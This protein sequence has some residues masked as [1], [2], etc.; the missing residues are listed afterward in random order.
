[1]GGIGRRCEKLGGRCS[2]KLRF[3]APGTSAARLRL[4]FKLFG[5]APPS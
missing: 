2:V 3:L 4:F 1:M 5:A